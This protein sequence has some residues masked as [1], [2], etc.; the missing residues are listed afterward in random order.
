MKQ[1]LYSLLFLGSLATFTGCEEADY[2]ELIPQEYN[3]IL[4]LKKCGQNDLVL[5][6]DGQQVKYS[7]TVVK[8]GSDPS[9][10]AQVRLS[11]LSQ[12][13]I[14]NESRYKGN[15]Y[16]VLNS[17]CY[18]FRNKDISF[19]SSDTYKIEEFTL[20]PEKIT[21]QVEA[22]ANANSIFILPIRLTSK[23][24][25]VNF[26][27]RDLILKPQVKQLGIKFEKS[28]TMID[29]GVNK[30]EEIIAGVINQWNFTAG[31]KASTDQTEIDAYNTA[32]GTDYKAVPEGAF[33]Q[34]EDLIFSS[35]ISE[36][37]GVL[38]VDRSKLT[39]GATY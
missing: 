36:S 14:D 8:S 24:D 1:I 35:G 19:E 22:E 39:K 26:E 23:T 34:L 33:Y 16:V 9:A 10:T 27:Q 3:K 21:E 6:N 4:N 28:S 2:Q 20:N 15:N 17:D 31:I 25:S 29:L 7:I 30:E 38:V 37:V 18:T 5:F 13:E 11:T 12:T 32:Q